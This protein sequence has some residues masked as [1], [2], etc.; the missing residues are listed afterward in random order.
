VDFIEVVL[1]EM[2]KGNFSFL[3]L[4][5][6]ILQLIVMIKRNKNEKTGGM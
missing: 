2:G 6:G 4:V 3:I 5:V 1:T